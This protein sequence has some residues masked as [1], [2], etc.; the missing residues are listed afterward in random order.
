MISLTALSKQLSEP[1]KPFDS[2]QPAQCGE[3]PIMINEQGQW[4]YDGSEITRPAMVKLF[5]SF[6]AKKVS[7]FI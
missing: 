3:L 2:W 4:F 5:A 6:Y 1:S 7:S